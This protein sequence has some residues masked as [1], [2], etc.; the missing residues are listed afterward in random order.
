VASIVKPLERRIAELEAGS[1]KYM[2]VYQ[3]AQAYKRGHVVTC[4]GSAWCCTRDG[5]SAEKPPGDGWQLMVK[6]GIQTARPRE[7]G[8]YASPRPR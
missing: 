2:G 6:S 3:P 1:M 8:H 4:D 5:V 7:N